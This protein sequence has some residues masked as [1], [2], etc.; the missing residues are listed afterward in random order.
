[1]PLLARSWGRGECIAAWCACCGGTFDLV[2]MGGLAPPVR[3]EGGNIE[4]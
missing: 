1:M 4:R 2:V 3:V